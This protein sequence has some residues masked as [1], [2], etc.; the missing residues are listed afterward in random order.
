MAHPREALAKRLIISGFILFV[1]TVLS[2][3]VTIRFVYGE[4]AAPPNGLL[5]T[6]AALALCCTALAFIGLVI[7]IATAK[8]R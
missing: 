6:F 2:T 7:L 1:L 4:G 3:F 5:L 8:K